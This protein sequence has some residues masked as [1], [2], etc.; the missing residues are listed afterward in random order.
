MREFYKAC[1]RMV[2][3]DEFKKLIQCLNNDSNIDYHVGTIE[4][5]KHDEKLFKTCVN[6]MPKGGYKIPIIAQIQSVG[7]MKSLLFYL[8]GEYLK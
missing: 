8:E 7:V 6:K 1:E 3:E 4:E 5:I 2:K